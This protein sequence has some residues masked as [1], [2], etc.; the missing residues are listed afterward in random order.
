MERRHRA[1]IH[2][3]ESL[4]LASILAECTT[5]KDS[6]LEG[7]AKDHPETNPITIKP[8]IGS[9]VTEQSSWVPL[10]SCSPPGH[11]FP[12]KPLALSAHVSP[13]TIHFRVLDKSPVSGPGRGPPSYNSA[14]VKNLPANAGDTWDVSLTSGSRKSLGKETA[15]LSSVPAWEAP[16]T[17]EHGGLHCGPWDHRVKHDWACTHTHTHTCVYGTWFIPSRQQVYFKEPF[18]FLWILTSML[19]FLVNQLFLIHSD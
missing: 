19:F 2:F 17:E 9:H 7:L 3:P 4:S 11:P 18:S 6:E 8:E 13:R 1:S 10:P 16:W 5:R 14:M 12:I 15:T